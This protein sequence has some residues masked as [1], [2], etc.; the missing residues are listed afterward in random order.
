MRKT[1]A[2]S[3]KMG[4]DAF[5]SSYNIG[6]CKPL[7]NQ[8]T[9]RQKEVL[10]LPQAAAT[11][12]LATR[13]KRPCKSVSVLCPDNLRTKPYVLHLRQFQPIPGRV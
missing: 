12:V 11:P 4:Q 9:F 2:N 1:N 8:V 3:M 7:I 10:S 5:V 13:R 6:A